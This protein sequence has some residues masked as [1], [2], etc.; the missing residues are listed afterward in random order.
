MAACPF[1]FTGGEEEI[2]EGTLGVVVIRE[3]ERD[4]LIEA[5]GLF[6]IAGFEKELGERSQGSEVFWLGGNDGAPVL[7]GEGE[8]ASGF[9]GAGFGDQIRNGCGRGHGREERGLE[10]RVK[11]PEGR[12]GMQDA[13]CKMR[14][15]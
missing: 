10:V 3:R 11:R 12:S 4:G 7:H 13:G 14:D 9:G 5:G 2:E 6:G 8:I 15:E 1:G